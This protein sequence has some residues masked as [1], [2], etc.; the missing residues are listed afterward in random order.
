MSI[1]SELSGGVITKDAAQTVYLGERLGLYLNSGSVVA[2]YGDLGTGKTTFA[3]GLAAGIGVAET[4]KSPSFNIYTVYKGQR[5][6]FVHVD[7][8]RL[9]SANQY[10]DLLIDE[11]VEDPKV[12][13]IEWPENIGDNLALNAI[14]LQFSISQDGSHLVKLL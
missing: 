11:I 12:L 7:A 14:K 6:P 2:L 3:K 10:D 13:C 5:M 4:V 9:N 8:Y 1:F